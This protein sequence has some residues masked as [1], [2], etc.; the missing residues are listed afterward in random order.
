MTY[1][2]INL[3][4]D[5]IAKFNKIYEFE[6]QIRGQQAQV[7][8]TS[9]SGHLLNKDF[10]GT[11]RSWKGC[12]PE[13]LFDAPIVKTCDER[14]DP[15]KRQLEREVRTCH[16]L[17][18]WTDCDREGENIG[19]EV[20]EVCQAIKANIQIYRA[21]FSDMTAASIARAVNNLQAPDQL[22]S[23]AVDVRSE[24]DLRIGAAFTRFQTLRLKQKFPN[25]IEENKLVSYGSCQFPTLGFVADRYREI[26]KFIKSDFW[27]IKLQHKINN[28]TV[29][30]NW[31]R[32]RLFDQ[33]CC[34]ALL[35]LCVAAEQ[36]TILN[37]QQKPKSKWRPQPMDTIELEKT[38]SRKLRLTA[39]TIMTIAEKLYTQGL[40]SYPRTETN[41]FSKDINLVP[42]VEMQTPHREWGEFAQMVV[43]W[44]PNPRNGNKSDQ[45]HP[46][47]HPTKFS[48]TLVGD[49]KR[50]Y[51]LI[52]RHFL[53]C[54][55]KDAVGSETIVNAEMG[56]EEFNATGLVIYERN[57]LDVYIYDKWSGKEIHNYE[58]NSTF[59]PTKLDIEKGQT[60]PPSLLTEADLIG[61]MEK[62][63]IGT[64]ATHAEHIATIKDR[65][66]IGEV[67]NG[68]LVPGKLGMALVEG[69]EVMNLT[70]SK[71]QLRA[72]LEVDL[73]RICEG[74]KNPAEVLSEQIEIYR[75]CFRI[76]IQKIQDLDRAMASRFDEEPME[77]DDNPLIIT[78]VHELF[79]CPKCRTSSMIIRN[80]KDNS[81]SFISCQGYPNCK[82]AIW[83]DKDLK[84]IVS[85]D[86]KCTTCDS[87]KVRFII[88]IKSIF[89]FNNYLGSAEIQASNNDGDGR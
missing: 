14:N 84:E 87:H 80:K 74:T 62:H 63:G 34:K 4:R 76:I 3:Q 73:K 5:G 17:V 47:I 26:E 53:A 9:V 59:I 60:S 35:N 23:L 72:G 58:I 85:L 89:Y 78:T 86:E 41:Q 24:L 19:F 6:A 77:V 83:L 33:D 13:Q 51:E 57:Y 39:K 22:Q 45:A 48:D 52:T 68:Q 27:K 37:V 75:N 20:I 61:L 40:I 56:G 88:L 28:L 44:G 32:N 8:M 42:L 25:Q 12:N 54:V 43:E 55:S 18:I 7:I 50:V 2:K 70:L 36:A 31:A 38:G 16:G 1:Y 69:Y 46:P 81:G 64:D 21:K 49:E 79:K 10:V 66:Y 67:N 65:E 30:F 71:P 15:I 82:H 29:D 11:Y